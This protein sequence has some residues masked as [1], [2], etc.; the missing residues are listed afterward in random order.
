MSVPNYNGK[1]PN[2]SAY[3]KNF[4][5]GAP[6]SL[7]KLIRYTVGGKSINALT[8]ANENYNTVYIPG[9]LYV[10][11]NIINPSDIYLKE[12]INKVDKKITDKLLNL[13]V[14]SF[15]FKDDPKKNIHYGFIAQ[16][17]EK[18]YKELVTVK[19]DKKYANIK[20]INYLEL[21]PLLVDKIQMMQKEIDELKLHI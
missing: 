1:Q 18:E 12:N 3:I 16:E 4:V 13:D 7:W 8:P 19:P 5:Y 2:N 14:S 20:A 11:G 9:D 21:I 6:I 15:C 10:D 17:F